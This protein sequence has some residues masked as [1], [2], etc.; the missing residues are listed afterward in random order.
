MPPADKGLTWMVS[1]HP[2]ITDVTSPNCNAYYGN[3]ATSFTVNYNSWS[4]RTCILLHV[5]I[6]LSKILWYHTWLKLLLIVHTTTAVTCICHVYSELQ[7]LLVSNHQ[8]YKLDR[9]ESVC[10]SVCPSVTDVTSLPQRVLWE[11]GYNVYR[12][13]Y[14][15]N[16]S[17]SCW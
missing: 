10:P 5:Y 15:G 9:C 13:A 14:A 3:E 16:E 7:L 8:Y 6:L 2:S 17:P 11:R 12:N 1:V 4:H